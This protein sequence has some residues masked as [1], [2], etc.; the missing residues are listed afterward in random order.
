MVGYLGNAP[1]ECN[2]RQIYSLDRLFNGIVTLMY[3]M[4]SREGIEPSLEL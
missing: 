1:S 3:K 4:V 2:A